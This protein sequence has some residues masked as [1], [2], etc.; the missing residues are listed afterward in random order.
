MGSDRGTSSNWENLPKWEGPAFAS[1]LA[2]FLGLSFQRLTQVFDGALYWFIFTVFSAIY[3]EPLKYRSWRELLLYCTLPAAWLIATWAILP[4]LGIVLGGFRPND[5]EKEFYLEL[6]VMGPIVFAFTALAI[7][8]WAVGKR[9]ILEIFFRPEKIEN[10]VKTLRGIG[11]ILSL[12]L[13]GV[14]YMKG[15]GSSK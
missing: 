5:R 8:F 9:H 14:L 7:A 2:F 4:A 12:I 10:V 1:I 11:L 15:I 13:T 6:S 3:I